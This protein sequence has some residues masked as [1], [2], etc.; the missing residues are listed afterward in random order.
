MA[1]PFAEK[2]VPSQRLDSI[3]LARFMAAFL[4]VLTHASFY[5][6]S[7]ISPGVDIWRSG[8]QGVNVFFVISGFV[9]MLSAD[10]LLGKPGAFRHF[11]AA[12]IIRIVPLYWT[13][14]LLKIALVIFIPSMAFAAPTIS[15]VIFS[16][17]FLPSRNAQGLI[18]TFYGVG[19]TLNFEM[20]FYV[21]VGLALLWKRPILPFAAPILLIMAA[22]S[23]ARTDT[24]PAITD[25]FRPILLNFLW[26]MIIAHFY[27]INMRMPFFIA[28]GSVSSSLAIILFLP[29]VFLFEL[30]F[31]LLIAGMVSLEPFLKGRVPRWAI[32]GGDASYS[33]YLVHPMAGVVTAIVLQRLH[34]NSMPLAF[35]VIVAACLAA[36]AATFMLVERPMTQALLQRFRRPLPG[37]S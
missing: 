35:L 15:N 31:A 1:I 22:L 10:P 29:D 9:M 8:A 23:V 21:L 12:R 4:V 14:N 2:N 34:V 25:L 16:M 33:L 5:V 24:W 32:W 18:E 27:S 13:L 17:L 11:A 36:S 20:F 3:Q 19:W 30:P 6:S 26:G 7:R 28:L 37:P